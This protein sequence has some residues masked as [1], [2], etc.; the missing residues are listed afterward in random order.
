[1][2]APSTRYVATPAG[3]IAYQVI[4]DG[5]IDLVFCPSWITNLDV[6]WEEPSMERFLRRLASFSR[7]L[8]FDK[9]GSGLSDPIPLGAPPTLEESAMDLRFVLDEVGSEH[10][11]I[12]AIEQ[13]CWIGILFAAAFP[14]HT[15]ALVLVDPFVRMLRSDAYP[16]GMPSATLQRFVE[17]TIDRWGTGGD[18]DFI[19]PELAGDL[20]FRSWYSRLE[21]ASMSPGTYETLASIYFLDETLDLTDVLPTVRVG[22]MVI[23]H[24]GHA[25]IRPEHGSY[26]AERI[27]GARYVERPDR[28]GLYWKHDVS[29]VLEAVEEFL[30][31]S[32][33]TPPSDDRV[34]A[35]VLFTDI[36]DST[37]QAA[38]LGD[39]RW[40]DLLDA[41]DSIMRRAIGEAR[42][43]IVKSTGDGVLATF[44]G[45]ARAIRC[46]VDIRADIAGLGIELRSGLHT[47]EIEVR[48][49]DVG[50]IAVHIGARVAA[51]A[52]AGEILVSSTVKDLVA[53]SGI[54][55]VER[56]R[57]ELKG[58]PG[59]W[60]LFVVSA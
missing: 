47:G 16:W 24:R 21:R 28:Y 5:P 60:S 59:E 9:R 45:P 55:F 11:A 33:R 4:G 43:R 23:S 42:G 52:A 51:T 30:T 22:T 29:G 41:H 38:A 20:R 40:R 34:L 53:G 19:A 6:M 36:V 31:G 2:T 50:G 26:I 37:R 17:G 15:S 32:R 7:L 25:W 35:T 39:E 58:I 1:M 54:E 56:G 57:Q 44:D 3:K 48:D 12:L 49:D 46:A 13:G 10:A 14:S 18:L 8:L 27:Q